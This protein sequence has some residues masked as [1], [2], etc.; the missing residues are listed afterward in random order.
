[1]QQKIRHNT[2]IK[3]IDDKELINA[4]EFVLLYVP[5]MFVCVLLLSCL[6]V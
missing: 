3:R 6:M 1:M 5:V 4:E 2:I